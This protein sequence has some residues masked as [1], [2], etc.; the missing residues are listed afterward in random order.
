MRYLIP[1]LL[2]FLVTEANSFLL[3]HIQNTKSAIELT[4]NKDED[5]QWFRRNT[6]VSTDLMRIMFYFLIDFLLKNELVLYLRCWLKNVTFVDIMYVV[7]CILMF[8]VFILIVVLSNF[9]IQFY[10]NDRRQRHIRI[11][12]YIFISTD[13]Y[14]LYWL[15]LSVQNCILNI[16]IDINYVF[17]CL[18]ISPQFIT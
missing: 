14:F 17:F 9:G 7:M 1:I 12:F 5:L 11:D 6:M 8:C 3:R 13:T 2:N 10:V 16:D 4:T 15:V 18:E